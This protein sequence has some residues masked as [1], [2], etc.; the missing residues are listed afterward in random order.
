L[1]ALQLPEGYLALFSDKLSR[2]T[3]DSRDMLGTAAL[4][5]ARFKTDDSTTL[6]DNST[7]TLM[8]RLSESIDQRILVTGKHELYFSHDQIQLAAA[9]LHSTERAIAT[10]KKAANNLVHQLND[11]ND[12]ANESERGQRLYSIAEHPKQGC[13]QT[14]SVDE[15]F[16]EA[17]FNLLAGEKALSALAHSAA[18]YYFSEAVSLCPDEGWVTH[19]DLMLTLYKNLARSALLMGEKERSNNTINIAMKHAKSDLDRA[20]CLLA[21]VVATTS[22]SNIEE[23][24]SLGLS[25]SH[26][27]KN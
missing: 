8:K 14:A 7:N 5:G 9:K 17:S 23:G 21:Q 16:N 11:S 19:Y 24:I 13:G 20:D 25:C 4:L 18:D 3:P 1:G 12:S 10:H 6:V 26:L 22:L 27:L 2:L 15:Q